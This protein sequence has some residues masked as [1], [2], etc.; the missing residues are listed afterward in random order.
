MW[1]ILVETAC[2]LD[3][4]TNFHG[5]RIFYSRIRSPAPKCV[6]LSF[7]L[8]T[9]LALQYIALLLNESDNR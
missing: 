2:F 5:L 9:C 7:G 1:N 3:V 6:G 4:H 8:I